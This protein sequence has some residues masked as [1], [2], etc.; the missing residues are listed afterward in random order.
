MY[1]HG[2]IP[3]FQISSLTTSNYKSTVL[4]VTG[5]ARI[6]HVG[7]QNLTNFQPFD[8]HNFLFQYGTATKISELVDNL[9]G[10]ITL[11][12]KSKY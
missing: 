8:S 4:N 1:M 12:T 9:F 2:L 3:V 11:L 10:F 5:P 6:G 7:S